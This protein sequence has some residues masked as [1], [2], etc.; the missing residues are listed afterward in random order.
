[1]CLSSLLKG[2]TLVR[3]YHR[4]NRIL[5]GAAL[6]GGLVLVTGA[7]AFALGHRGDAREIAALRGAG[8]D[9]DRSGGAPPASSGA[10]PEI[11]AS[12]AASA[13]ALVTGGL[14]VILARR[15]H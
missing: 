14:L 2:G 6:V 13:I 15:R 10:V 3:S 4:F 1:M 12:A 9:Q 7:P 5:L 11:D 8:S